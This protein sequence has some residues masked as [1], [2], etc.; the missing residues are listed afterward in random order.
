MKKIIWVFLLFAVGFSAEAGARDKDETDKNVIVPR[1]R[2]CGDQFASQASVIFAETLKDMHGKLEY[3]DNPRFGAGFFH[4]STDTLSRPNYYKQMW[5]RDCGRGV[6]ELARFG[7]ADD[8]KMV[9]RYFLAHINLKDHWGR[10]IHRPYIPHNAAELD[11]NAWILSAICSAWKVNGRDRKLGKEFCEGI[12]PVVGWV[13]SLIRVSPYGGLLPSISELSGNPSVKY[14]VYSIFGN[15]GM[16]VSLGM[17]ADMAEASGE[18]LLAERAEGLQAKMKEALATLVSDGKISYAPKGCWFNGFDSRTGSAYDISDWDGT[19]WPIWHWTRQLPYIQDYDAGCNRIGGTFDEIHRASYSLLR[20]WMAKGE[21]FRKY[22]FVSNS[23]WTGMGERHDETMCGY[24]QG[25]F[26]QAALMA[27]DV[28]TYSK[29]LEGIARLGYDGGV[30]EHMSYERNPFVMNECFSYDNYETGLD[31]TFGTYKNGRREIMENPSDEG[32]LVQ[33]SEILKAFALVVG[34]SCEDG[35]LVI[36]PRLPWL[37]DTMECRDFPVTDKNGK[38]QR[39]NLVYKHERWLGKCT[40]KINGAEK[41]DA[42]DVRFGPFPRI[43][44]NRAGFTLEESD[45]CSWVWV[46]NQKN[47]VRELSVEI[48]FL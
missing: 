20:H 46:R 35:R 8:A 4:T 25:F 14:T 18:K 12:L 1:I 22:G 27:D 38:V 44:E 15:Y 31:H 41:F 11:G 10:E 30:I 3:G 43:T 6:M 47:T 48:P 7:F 9:A 21:Y 34:V 42:V 28:N 40:L 39:I 13:D 26:T 29:C 45:N 17:I 36:M 16:Y 24:G 32:N 23:G 19:A 33:E 2:F 5:A 37:W